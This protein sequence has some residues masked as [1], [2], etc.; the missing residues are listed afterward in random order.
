MY[1]EWCQRH[2]REKSRDIRWNSTEWVQMVSEPCLAA[3]DVAA[4]TAITIEL[5]QFK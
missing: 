4:H 1:G 3:V 2:V 5:Q